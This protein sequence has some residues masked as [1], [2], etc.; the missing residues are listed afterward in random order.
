MLGFRVACALGVSL[1][2]LSASV[3]WAD[4]ADSSATPAASD[5]QLQ[6][7]IVTAQRKSERLQDVPISINAVNAEMMQNRGIKDTFDLQSV[8]PGLSMTRVATVS[9]PYLRG[10]GSDGANPNAEASVA[11]KSCAPWAAFTMTSRLGFEPAMRL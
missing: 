2:A 5:G 9:T 10:V 6:D 8:V 3:A 1:S 7:I 4:N 11:S